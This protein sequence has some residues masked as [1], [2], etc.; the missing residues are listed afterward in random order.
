M[1]NQ[2]VSYKIAQELRELGFAEPCLCY[3]WRTKDTF[4]YDYRSVIGKNHNQLPTRISAPLWQQAIKF[5]NGIGYIKHINVYIKSDFIDEKVL[6]LEIL[7]AIEL[8]KKSS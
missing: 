4:H 5:L 2:S 8:I 1:K 6:E 7:E 3:Y